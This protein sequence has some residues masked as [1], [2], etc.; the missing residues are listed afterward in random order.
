MKEVCHT[1]INTVCFQLHEVPQQSNSQRQKVGWW[2][3]GAGGGRELEF[4]FSGYK[5]SVG[6]DGKVLERDGEV[7]TM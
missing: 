3:L 7:C 4:L 5:V 6:E 1:K 2:L